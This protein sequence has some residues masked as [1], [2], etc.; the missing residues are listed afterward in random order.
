[1]KTRS[2][3]LISKKYLLKLALKRNI[4]IFKFGLGFD[5]LRPIAYPQTSIFLVCF[6]VVYPSSLVNVQKLWVNEIKKYCPSTPFILVGTKVD[7]RSSQEHIE[8]LAKK[9]E[10]PV[11][12]EEGCR[13]A[14]QLKAVKYVECSALNQQGI[15]DVFDEAILTVLNKPKTN[16]H[17][18]C[19]L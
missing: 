12:Y 19:I 2:N 7:L 15:R 3:S 1:M 4:N 18:C 14:K 11:T 5:Q 13:V 10:R 9:K 8:R 17:K 6:S 16:S